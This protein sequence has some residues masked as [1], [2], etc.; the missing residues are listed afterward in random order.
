MIFMAPVSQGAERILPLDKVQPGM[1]GYGY[2]VFSGTKVEKFKVKVI[3]TVDSSS[4]GKDK[5]ILVRLSGKALEENGGLSAGMSGSPVYFRNRLAGAIS[6]G[7]ENADPFLA[8]VTP[9]DSM[10][11]MLDD[12]EKTA[13]LRN[14]SLKPIPVATPLMISGMKQRSFELVSR[15]LE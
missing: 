9:I 15:L 11:K 1:N 12:T 10:L 7:F 8:L 14:Y 2:T 5:L 4:F 6:Y 13:Y 3:A